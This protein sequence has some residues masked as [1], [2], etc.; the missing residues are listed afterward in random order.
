MLGISW[1]GAQLAAS[2]EG[3]SSMKLVNFRIEEYGFYERGHMVNI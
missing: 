1:V 3:L 2:Q